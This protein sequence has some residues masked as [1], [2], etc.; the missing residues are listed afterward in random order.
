MSG[1]SGNVNPYD[2][3][4]MGRRHEGG[5]GTPDTVYGQAISKMP[6]A[7]G[8]T[9]EIHI[10]SGNWAGDEWA[11]PSSENEQPGRVVTFDYCYA[12]QPKMNPDG[13]G[14]FMTRPHQKNI[15]TMPD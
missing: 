10:T 9:H 5:R 3:V 12:A 2:N 14:N 8:H 4:V 6:G 1:P 13:N 11:D 7:V 15:M